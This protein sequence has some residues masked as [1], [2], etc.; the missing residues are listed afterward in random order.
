MTVDVGRR[1]PE[2]HHGALETMAVGVRDP[3]QRQPAVILVAAFVL[4]VLDQALVIDDQ[5][6][7]AL[8]AVRSENM[9]KTKNATHGVTT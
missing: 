7:L 1:F 6:F 9:L 3:G 2:A 5:P 8:E 4:D